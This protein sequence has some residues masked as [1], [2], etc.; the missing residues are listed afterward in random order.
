MQLFAWNLQCR[1]HG[2]VD[3]PK[4]LGY[5]TLVFH[6]FVHSEHFVIWRGDVTVFPILKLNHDN[7]I[8]WHPFA[9]R[10]VFLSAQQR[11]VVKLTDRASGD[12]PLLADRLSAAAWDDSLEAHCICLLLVLIFLFVML[13]HFIDDI[14]VFLIT[15]DFPVEKFLYLMV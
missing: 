1:V 9:W 11:L 10:Q 3:W 15:L 13:L 6:S 2:Q 8:L 5:R 4:R 14:H 12:R 7:V